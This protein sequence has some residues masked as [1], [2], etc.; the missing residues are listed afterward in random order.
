MSVQFGKCNLDGKPVDLQELDRVRAVLAPYGPDA[1]GSF[2]KDNAGIIYRAFHTT[3]E[4][5]LEVQPHVGPS[6]AVVT[7][8]GR[9]DNRSGLI[10]ELGGHLSSDSTD[11]SI[12]TA[13]Y[14]HWG[15]NSLAKLIGD[16]ALSIWDPDERSLLLAKDLV[17]TRHLYYSIDKHNVT[18][19]TLIEPLVLFAGKTFALCEEYI[20]GWFSFFPATHLTP[21]LG[22]HSVPPSS[23]V[24]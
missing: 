17:G 7:W 11:L 8:D 24:L 22:I 15:R 9:L 19:S 1:E 12:V 2:C 6:G 4:S 13:A 21:Y 16:W 5:R 18:W 20:A 10:H 14:E 3:K 23:F